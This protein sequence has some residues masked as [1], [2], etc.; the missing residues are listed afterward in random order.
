MNQFQVTVT[1]SRAPRIR[2]MPDDL[3]SYAARPTPQHPLA[4]L[5]VLVVED[6]RFAC[7]AMRLL[8]LR[9]GARIRRADTLRAARRHL[10]RYRPSVLLVDP[11]LPDGS[12]IDLIAEQALARPR[13]DVI[14]AVS[15]DP[16]QEEAALAAGAQGFLPKPFTSLDAFQQAILSR[17]PENPMPRAPRGLAGEDV[18][19]DEAAL[20]DDLAQAA[21][22]L[23]DIDDDRDLAYLTQFLG[24][25]AL[26]A[27]DGSLRDA[28][29]RLRESCA[30]G[31]AWRPDLARVAGL[32]QARLTQRPAV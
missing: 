25:V 11:G 12:G 6:S 4:G 28:T 8:C 18:H 7:E 24:S 5:T 14:L 20:L 21:D 17:L 31:Q 10:Q 23:A 9:S 27:G 15:G 30:A 22:L 19:P 1:V 16:A 3:F 2:G 32:V 29:E 13:V 26:A